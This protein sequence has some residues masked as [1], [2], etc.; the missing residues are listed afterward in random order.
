[1]IVRGA[2]FELQR[3]VGTGAT[4]QPS[5]NPSCIGSV[6]AINGG[7]MR[8]IPD[9]SVCPG[10][11]ET[12]EQPPTAPARMIAAVKPTAREAL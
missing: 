11:G 4:P 3:A 7:N 2:Q 12:P 1:M 10:G 6:I 8:M 5:P 9:N